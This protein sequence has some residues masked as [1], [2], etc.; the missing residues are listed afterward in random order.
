MLL[1]FSTKFP[2][3][4][5]LML[6]HG[7]AT[8]QKRFL[9]EFQLFVGK[10]DLQ[11]MEVQQAPKWEAISTPSLEWGVR[12]T[13]PSFSRRIWQFTQGPG[14]LTLDGSSKPRFQG[15]VTGLCRKVFYSLYNVSWWRN[16]HSSCHSN[17]KSG[18]YHGVS[19]LPPFTSNGSPNSV[20]S[21]SCVSFQ[22]SASSHFYILREGLIVVSYAD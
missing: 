19:S 2:H 21:V 6:M 10:G 5:S 8:Q 20:N 13:H 12:G 15:G 18:N 17:E 7:R 11:G 1:P 3:L 16:Y 14:A 4:L 22:S 9:R